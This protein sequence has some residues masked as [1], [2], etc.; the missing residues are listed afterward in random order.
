MKNDEPKTIQNSWRT[1]GMQNNGNS[2]MVTKGMQNNGNSIWC[3]C[4]F[5][6]AMN[7]EL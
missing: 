5:F 4:V 3:V 1:K 7:R 6:F 2:I